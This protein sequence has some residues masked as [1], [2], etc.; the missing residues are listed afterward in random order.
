VRA[1]AGWRDGLRTRILR[2]GIRA[3]C[4]S[5]DFVSTNI[6]ADISLISAGSR[7]ALLRL[8][9]ALGVKNFVSKSG[10]GYDFVCHI[11]DLAE[12]PFYHRRVFERELAICAA[13]LHQEDK[14]V[15]YDL[16]ANVGFVST[17][18]AQMLAPRSPQIYAFEP[19]PATFERLVETVQ[20]L[21]LSA[22]VHPIAAAVT[23]APKRVR[24][25]LSKGNSLVTQV[26]MGAADPGP[27]DDIAVADGITLDE[28][29]AAMGVHP[30]FIKMDVEG[31]E[32]AALRG[33]AR[34][35][36]REDRPAMIFEYNRAS[37]V[38]CGA[39]VDTL[40]E[41]LAPYSLYYV[42]DLQGQLL[43]F[44]SPVAELGG[45]HWICNLFAAPRGDVSSGRWASALSYAQHWMMHPQKTVT[46]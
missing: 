44:G 24:I 12:F 21:G 28:F 20:R 13:W 35:L 43:P 26:V 15:V 36:S 34:L 30:A 8:L 19:A 3:V 9:G 10:L 40:R 45:I 32:L 25:A 41:L 39:T 4:G 11:G 6:V 33:A 27:S 22:R 42:D 2:R 29:G 1:L 23:D 31:S 46:S 14:P 16:G 17:H 38:Q 7:F 5:P 18:L 37:I